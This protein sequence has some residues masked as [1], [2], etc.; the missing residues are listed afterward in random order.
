MGRKHH[1]PEHIIA[2][3]REAEVLLSQGKSVLELSRHLGIA[4]QR[5]YRR[6]NEYGGL[7]PPLAA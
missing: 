7:M 6:R 1:S 5:Y 3:P 2:K 4:E